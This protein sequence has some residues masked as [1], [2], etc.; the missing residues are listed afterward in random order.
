MNPLSSCNI[1]MLLALAAPST[2]QLQFET[3][4]R[5]HLPADR[6]STTAAVGARDVD[7][8]GDVDL[9]VANGVQSRLY[10]N[11]GTGIFTDVTITQMPSGS[12][13]ASDLAL[14][15]VDGDGDVDVV[16]ANQ[17]QSELF[18]ND[19]GGTFTDATAGRMPLASDRTRAVAM[20]D[21]DGDGDGDLVLANDRTQNRLY[22]NDGNGVF[23]DAT[24]ARMPVEND[25]T[26]AVALG[27]VNGDGALD[28]V[29]G[30][31]T[32]NRLYVNDG[33]GTFTDAT[34]ARLPRRSEATHAIGLGD[35]DRDGDADLVFANHM[36]NQ[37]YLNDG[38]GFYIDATGRLPLDNDISIAVALGDADGD[39]DPDLTFANANLPGAS[40][41][42]LYLNDGAGRFSDATAARMPRDNDQSYAVTL[43]DLDGD[44]DS[45]L[46][47]GNGVFQQSRLY[48]NDGAGVF[49]NASAGPLPA[50]IGFTQDVAFG[51]V[52]RDG[53]VDLV[54]ANSFVRAYVL[55]FGTALGWDNRLYLNDGNGVFVNATTARMPPDQDSSEA[56]ALGDVDGDGDLDLIFGNGD[57]TYYGG[58]TGQPNRLYLNDGTG[59]FTDV[60]STHLPGDR[61]VT[62]SVALGDVD[63]D[64]DLDLMVGNGGGIYGPAQ[65]NRLYL[66]DGAGTFA[67]ASASQLPADIDRTTS[68]SFGDVDGDDDLDLILGNWRGPNR[69][70]LNDSTGIFADLTPDRLPAG[71]DSTAAVALGDVDGD[72]DLDLVAGNALQRCGYYGYYS[73]GSQDRLYLN[74]GSGRFSDVTA[75]RM[76]PATDATFDV[77]LGD[78][79]ADGDLD[80]VAANRDASRLYLNDGSGRFVDATAARLSSESSLSLTE[81]VALADVD[82]DADADLVFGRAGG[83]NL[84]LTN[85]ARHLATPW[86]A[87]LGRELGVEAYARHA[88]GPHVV[89][90]YVSAATAQI[91]VPALGTLGLDPALMIPLPVFMIPP[92]AGV[93]S[94]RLSI[95]SHPSFVGLPLFAQA[96]IV[97][98]APG[99]ARLTNVTAD[100]IV[101]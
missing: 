101:R 38:S 44:G 100:R 72:G 42:R 35:V 75:A 88:V 17:R 70:Y 36:Q 69:L 8:D 71:Q 14:G 9:L 51:D 16:L 78:V 25:Y 3:L 66:N 21:V 97:G 54:V 53:D 33:A 82:A 84:L 15:D 80:L 95:P 60:S 23:T 28:L 6:D 62:T 92:A 5:R 94:L 61:D 49:E 68:V 98:S 90:P 93:G 85:L 29:F 20:G 56:V 31:T 81:S 40:Q 77:A 99:Q 2:A 87:V 89:L 74:D 24:A 19:G 52:D 59:A 50:D 48:L 63:G 12:R 11:E 67:D 41:N 96:V 73:C 91:P 76:P 34:M 18:L 86:L 47:F 1:V 26:L 22:L 55:Y 30:N 32:A 13:G 27:D 58:G 4:T 43:G 39:G 46:V 10:V 7:G 83:P 45:D 57:D 79:D 37:L 65:P 64:G